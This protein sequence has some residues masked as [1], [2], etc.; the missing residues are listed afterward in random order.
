MALT[1]L[2]SA[3][4]T[5]SAM[6]ATMS[7]ICDNAGRTFVSQ[8]G[9]ETF[10]LRSKVS[11][12]NYEVTDVS[13]DTVVKVT[14]RDTGVIGGFVATMSFD[15]Q[16]YSTTNPVTDSLWQLTDSD[17]GVTDPLVYTEFTGHNYHDDNP[18]NDVSTDAV[19][20]WNGNTYNTMTFEFA[21]ADA[22]N[23]CYDSSSSAAVSVGGHYFGGFGNAAA[24]TAVVITAKDM[25]IIGL[26][27]MNLVIVAMVC[28]VCAKKP[29][30][31]VRYGV[32]SMA[33]DSEMRK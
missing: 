32:V 30:A 14:C 7:M 4:A 21:F 2:A 25:V 5:T 1:L 23:Y 8:D 9:G 27:F 17:D 29:V 28:M 24:D 10:S 3:V 19:W 15:G 26:V 18:D 31:K 20:I 6:T 11:N 13:V 22:Y 33:S 16:S 12:Q